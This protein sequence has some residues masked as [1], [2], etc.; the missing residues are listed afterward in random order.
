[1]RMRYLVLSGSL[2]LLVASG[3]NAED[4]LTGSIDTHIGKIEL[5]G[6]YPSNDSIKK[7]YDEID[8]ERATQAY[9]WATPAS[10]PNVA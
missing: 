8:F 3:A 10:P 7:L 5:Q 6:G 2:I 1:M 9:V 4:V